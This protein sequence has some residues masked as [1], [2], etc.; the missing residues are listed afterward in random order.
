MAFGGRL[1]IRKRRIGQIVIRNNSPQQKTIPATPVAG[2]F[3]RVVQIR[4][5]ISAPS[6]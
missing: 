2:I 3:A 1:V 6:P 5:V 4:A